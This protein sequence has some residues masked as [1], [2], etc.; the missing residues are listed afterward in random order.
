VQRLARLA[1]PCFSGA[2]FEEIVRRLGYEIGEE[3]HDDAPSGGVTNGDVEKDIR[4]RS[5]VG[6]FGDMARKTL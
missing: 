2:Q 5:S 6:H 4:A 3:R 1:D